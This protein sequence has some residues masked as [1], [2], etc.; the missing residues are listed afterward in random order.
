[1]RK[2]TC[3]VDYLLGLLAHLEPTNE[4]FNPNFRPAAVVKFGEQPTKPMVCNADH[5]FTNLP[6]LKES[7]RKGKGNT[8]LYLSKEERLD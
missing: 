6:L 2:Y 1:L 7:E 8:A 5:F 4:I 3:N